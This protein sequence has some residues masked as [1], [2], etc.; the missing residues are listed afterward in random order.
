M[1]KYIFIL[2][3]LVFSILGVNAQIRT[4][5]AF[6]S[7]TVVN[8]KV[9]FEQFI[10]TGQTLSADQKYDLLYKWG[11]NNYTG[12]PLLSGIRFNDRDR[13]ITVSSKVNLLLPVNEKGIQEKMFM[14]YRFDVSVTNAGCMLVIR[15]ITYQSAQ[16]S[17]KTFFP[18][19]YAAEEMITDAAI[20]SAS[21]ADR[22]FKKNTQRATLSFFDDLYNDLKNVF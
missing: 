14:H 4:E 12:D 13:S 3:L 6:T 5:S 2:G 21:D 10:R 15:D 18:K 19:I 22:E 20:S 1:K 16:E 8:G 17:E 7:V 11:K 9:T